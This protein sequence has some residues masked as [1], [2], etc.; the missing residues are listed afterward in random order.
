MDVDIRTYGA[1]AAALGADLHPVYAA[2]FGAEPYLESAEQAA[3]WR[4]ETL[5]EH[6]AYDG[7]R[8]LVAW[9]GARAVGFGY[10][11]TGARGQPWTDKLVAAV[12]PA[13]AA[14]WIGGHFELVELAVSPEHHGRG[15]GA[16][17]HDGMLTGLPHRDALLMTSRQDTPARRLYLR[18]GWQVVVA[19]L[20]DTLSLLGRTL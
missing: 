14:R 9:S 15:I 16:A 17:L 6:A 11:Y 18:R 7:F 12:P 20:F 5:P 13:V 3:R 10:G 4:D 2:A 8:C 1:E 19:E